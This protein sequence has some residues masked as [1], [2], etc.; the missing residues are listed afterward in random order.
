MD[1]VENIC[2]RSIE[3]VVWQ[4]VTGIM[5]LLSGSHVDWK[6]NEQKI[7]YIHIPFRPYATIQW[8]DNLLAFGPVLC[9]MHWSSFG[10]KSI[11]KI[12]A[13]RSAMVST[14][15]R[16]ADVLLDMVIYVQCPVIHFGTLVPT[17]N[18]EIW[19]IYN[20]WFLIIWPN[21]IRLNRS[22]CHVSFW[23]GPCH[24]NEDNENWIKVKRL[25]IVMHREPL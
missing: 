12:N 4:N 6:C 16:F 7:W 2:S 23:G 15:Q 8:V 14:P 25:R 20:I 13:S 18:E 24:K 5:Y 22:W 21:G 10:W 11:I 17:Q 9:M 19:S 3:L 1:P